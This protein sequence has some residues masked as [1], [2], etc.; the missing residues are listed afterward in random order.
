M[1][2]I[3]YFDQKEIVKLLDRIH[4]MD[5]GARSAYDQILMPLVSMCVIHDGFGMEC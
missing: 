2:S 3:P 5:A 4:T 1:K